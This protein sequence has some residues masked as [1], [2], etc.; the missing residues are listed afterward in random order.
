MHCRSLNL[1]YVE[2]C[3]ERFEIGDLVEVGLGAN[4][5]PA[6]S[7]NEHLHTL[8]PFLLLVACGSVPTAKRPGQSIQLTFAIHIRS[9]SA[10]SKWLGTGGVPAR[11]KH[12]VLAQAGRL[13]H[14]VF[15]AGQ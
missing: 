8:R 6:G 14:P 15:A 3:Q 11:G 1:E 10:P 5:L 9:V 12:H 2:Y 7:F 4:D 13:R